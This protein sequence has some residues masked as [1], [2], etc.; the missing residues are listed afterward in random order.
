MP[1]GQGCLVPVLFRGVMLNTVP[2]PGGAPVKPELYP[3]TVGK[4]DGT[5]FSDSVIYVNIFNSPHL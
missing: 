3:N 4:A 5:V 2:P 1:D